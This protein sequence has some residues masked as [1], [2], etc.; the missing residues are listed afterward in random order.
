MPYS[1]T[2][3]DNRSYSMFS[4]SVPPSAHEKLPDNF[5]EISR[6]HFYFGRAPI[7][8]MIDEVEKATTEHIYLGMPQLAFSVKELFQYIPLTHYSSQKKDVNHFI[9]IMFKDICKGCQ[10]ISTEIINNPSNKMNVNIFNVMV[11]LF[12]EIKFIKESMGCDFDLNKTSDDIQQ[13][14]INIENMKNV[15]PHFNDVKKWDVIK[16]EAISSIK[17][18]L[19]HNYSFNINEL[20]SIYDYYGVGDSWIRELNFMKSQIHNNPEGYSSSEEDLKSTQDIYVRNMKSFSLVLNNGAINYM[21][22]F[23]VSLSLEKHRFQHMINKS[24][25]AYYHNKIK[26]LE[27]DKASPYSTWGRKEEVQLESLL[28]NKEMFIKNKMKEKKKE[29]EKIFNCIYTEQNI[30]NFINTLKE[31]VLGL[32]EEQVSTTS[33]LKVYRN[34]KNNTLLGEYKDKIIYVAPDNDEGMTDDMVV[35]AFSMNK[36][37]FEE[38]SEDTLKNPAL[39]K[40]MIVNKP[41]IKFTNFHNM[42]AFIRDLADRNL[43]EFFFSEKNIKIE[44]E[45]MG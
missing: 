20:S 34:E 40:D 19:S 32:N 25:L 30:H 21:R 4:C 7:D 15:Y 24:C 8:F 42:P 13:S 5:K 29:E 39:I 43:Q 2:L 14:F 18:Q 26:E 10:K 1:Y 44:N 36:K 23:L 33:V 22:S 16:E 17:E 9:N 3:L 28:A 35:V 27:K 11:Q 41:N 38:L 45:I 6:I 12:E 31:K 37:D